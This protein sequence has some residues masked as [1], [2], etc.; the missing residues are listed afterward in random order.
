[1]NSAMF[2]RI[3]LFLSSTKNWFYAAVLLSC[4]TCLPHLHASW[5]EPL[6]TEEVRNAATVVTSQLDPANNVNDINSGATNS[7]SGIRTINRTDL[8]HPLGVQVLLVELKEQKQVIDQAARIAE[9]FIFNYQT[10]KSELN[11][12]DVEHNQ[13]ISKRE[14]NSVHLPLSEQE[15]EYSKALI[16]NNTEFAEQ[17]QAEYENLISSVS[18][19]N[20]SNVSDKLQTQISIWVPN[21]NVE[22]QSE[23]C[24]QNRCA[25]ISVFTQDNYNFSIEPVINLMS[26]QIYFDLVR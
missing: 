2:F 4:T 24:M 18:N 26:G 15:I 20:S 11:L 8:R 22:R 5:Q 14:I 23:I 9:V 3:S 13:L 17:I 12:V 6:N 25:L 7:T 19:T 10:G 16:W 21:S 1:M